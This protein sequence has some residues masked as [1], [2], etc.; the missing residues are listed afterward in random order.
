MHL[1]LLWMDHWHC[2][3]HQFVLQCHRQIHTSLKNVTERRT[4]G[5]RTHRL[6][7]MYPDIQCIG[8]IRYSDDWFPRSFT[9]LSVVC[10]S[11]K[12]LAEWQANP[13]LSHLCF[14]SKRGQK[15]Y[16]LIQMITVTSSMLNPRLPYSHKTYRNCYKT[17]FPQQILT[18]S[19]L[20]W[21]GALHR[22]KFKYR[23]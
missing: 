21:W 18:M 13:C 17:A 11:D 14:V 15:V 16:L 6:D 5:S 9:L 19:K 12:H 20:G 2:C 22:I 10:K 8:S 23:I 1:S 7:P 3:H 4:S